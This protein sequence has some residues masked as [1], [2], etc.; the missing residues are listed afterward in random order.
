MTVLPIIDITSFLKKKK[1]TSHKKSQ[2]SCW[3]SGFYMQQFRDFS[4]AT[5]RPGMETHTHEEQW[6]EYSATPSSSTPSQVF[7]D[8][9][10]SRDAAWIPVVHTHKSKLQIM[11][12]ALMIHVMQLQTQES[13]QQTHSFR[14]QTHGFRFQSHATSI[15]RDAL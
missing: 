7:I 5:S 8:I 11:W 13:R 4:N 10:G 2:R 3:C 6:E 9:S 14:F 1:V 12:N 15:S